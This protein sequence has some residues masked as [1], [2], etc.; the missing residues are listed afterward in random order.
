MTLAD[1][2]QG[3]LPWREVPGY[4]LAQVVGAFVGV[5]VAHVMFKE[6]ALFCPSPVEERYSSD[7]AA[8]K[9]EGFYRD[10]LDRRDRALFS[11]PEAL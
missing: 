3:G 8:Q 1:A 6:P 10:L 11:L 2:S 4:L 5:A 7:T 9:L